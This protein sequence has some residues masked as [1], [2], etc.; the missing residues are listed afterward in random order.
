MLCRNERTDVYVEKLRLKATD[1]LV[2]KLRVEITQMKE[3][4]A[5]LKRAQGGGG[6]N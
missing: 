2:K 1:N 4:N 5:S 6:Q 3:E